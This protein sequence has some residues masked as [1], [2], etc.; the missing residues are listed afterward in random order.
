MRVLGREDRDA[1]ASVQSYTAFC[2]GERMPICTMRRGSISPSRIAWIEDGPV[3]VGLAE[4]LGPR[5]HMRVEVHQ[6]QRPARLS[7]ARAAAAG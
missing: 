4:V 3:R 1:L 6:R 5:V 7:V 2:T